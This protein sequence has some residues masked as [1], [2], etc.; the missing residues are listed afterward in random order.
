MHILMRFAL[1][2]QRENNI[3]LALVVEKDKRWRRERKENFCVRDDDER[4]AKRKTFVRFV[5]EKWPH[6]NYSKFF[7]RNNL[8]VS[9]RMSSAKDDRDDDNT[10]CLLYTS[11]S[12]RDRT[13][14]RMPSSA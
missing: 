6:E 12:P 11:P 8:H 9:N 2:K 10:I 13:R 4:K 14:S 1:E 3:S 7:L 5:Y